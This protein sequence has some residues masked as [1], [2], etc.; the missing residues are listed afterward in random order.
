M[1]VADVRKRVEPLPAT[2]WGW[3]PRLLTTHTSLVI[4]KSGLD[5]YFLLRYLRMMII[6]FG[7]G[8]IFFWPILLPIN[9]VNQI[10]SAGNITGMDILSI[11]NIK[12]TKRYWAHVIV[13]IAFIS[14][15]PSFYS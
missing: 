13:A 2:P 1:E 10:G 3:I 8:I 15:I 7:G 12:D 4:N 5:G 6:L 9:A 11:S 14:W